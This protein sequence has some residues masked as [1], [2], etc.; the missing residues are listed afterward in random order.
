MNFNKN[1]FDYEF[2]EILIRIWNYFWCTNNF[3]INNLRI[4]IYSSARYKDLR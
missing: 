4:S 3:K 1:N 2:P